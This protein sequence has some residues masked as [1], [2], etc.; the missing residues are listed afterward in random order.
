MTAF[1]T[2]IPAGNTGTFDYL[3]F[4]EQN[5]NNYQ[6]IVNQFGGFS[7]T[8]TDIGRGF[9]EA[10]KQIYERINDAE[11]ARK[12]REALR[13]IKNYFKPDG[14]YYLNN[15]EDLQNAQVRMQRFIMAEPTIRDLYHN[16]RCDG[17]SDTYV[18]VQ[19]G[20]IGNNHYD[21]RRVMDGI[22]QVHE[23]DNGESTFTVNTYLED[24]KDGDR[25]L[26]FDEQCNILSTWEIVQMYIKA[27]NDPTNINGGDL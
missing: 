13:S 26:T 9:L 12:A 21:Y 14:I 24:L 3:M 1:I 23:L 2:V 27:G 22:V 16:Q 15:L 11:F 25:N 6:Y 8:L 20:A 4:P 5:M 7:N 19:P 18:D 10:S 17:Y